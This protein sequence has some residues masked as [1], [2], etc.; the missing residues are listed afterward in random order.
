MAGPALCEPPCA[1]FVAGAIQN[2]FSRDT[3]DAQ[4]AM[5]FNRK[6]GS[7]AGKSSFA[8][9]RVRDGLGSCSDHARNR[10]SIVVRV[11]T[12]FLKCRF[13]GRHSTL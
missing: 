5:F 4:N 8:E 6:G 13:R 12:C 3:A 7:E 2:A 1:D 11:C 9:R 10:P